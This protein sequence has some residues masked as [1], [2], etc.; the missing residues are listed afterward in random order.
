M[1]NL[2]RIKAIYNSCQGKYAFPCWVN[3]YQTH[4]TLSEVSVFMKHK[5]L[6]VLS[7]SFMDTTL[8]VRW[9]SSEEVT[10]RGGQLKQIAHLA[11]GSTSPSLHHNRTTFV[12][13][14]L[15]K[16]ET[17][18]LFFYPCFSYFVV[19]LFKTIN[20]TTWPSKGIPAV[21]W[22]RQAAFPQ[23]PTELYLRGR[24]QRHPSCVYLVLWAPLWLWGGCRSCPSP[25]T[26]TGMSQRSPCF[27]TAH[28]WHDTSS[29][30]SS[31]QLYRLLRN[32]PAALIPRAAVLRLRCWLW[33]PALLPVQILAPNFSRQRPLL[34]HSGEAPHWHRV[35]PQFVIR[36]K[37]ADYTSCHFLK[38]DEN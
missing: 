12:N 8:Q 25:C 5:K 2:L 24:L 22:E 18:T 6:H 19:W 17:G 7:Q 21:P 29:A 4:L 3:T 33:I 32:A 35:P 31:K 20:P 28:T 36:I 9:G 34:T 27:T 11:V 14:H 26:V 10:T 15:V 13:T 30:E 37:P 1:V 16:L 38:A 23:P